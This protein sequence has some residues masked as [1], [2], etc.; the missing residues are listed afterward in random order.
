MD[1][2]YLLHDDKFYDSYEVKDEDDPY[3]FDAVKIGE[4]SVDDDTP[5]ETNGA[6]TDNGKKSDNIIEVWIYGNEGDRIPHLHFKSQKLNLDGCIKLEKAEYFKHCSHTSTLTDK[7]VKAFYDFM[8]TNNYK[9]KVNNYDLV[10]NIWNLGVYDNVRE[11]DYMANMPDYS[12]L[13]D[14]SL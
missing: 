3:Y 10:V 5:E 6:S 12:K 14:N 8:K 11:I 4:F 7:Q 13:N 1:E 2:E 9:D